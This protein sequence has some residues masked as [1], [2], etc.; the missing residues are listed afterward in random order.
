MTLGRA[1]KSGKLFWAAE[2]QRA[3]PVEFATIA[4]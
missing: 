4:L 3:S 2:I 1:G